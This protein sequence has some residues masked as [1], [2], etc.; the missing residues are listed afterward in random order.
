MNLNNS[1]LLTNHLKTYLILIISLITNRI[2]NTKFQSNLTQQNNNNKT[3]INN[4]NKNN[5]KNNNKNNSIPN[6]NTHNH[7]FKIQVHVNQ[8]NLRN[9]RSQSILQLCLQLEKKIKILYLMLN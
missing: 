1:I 2:V 8:Q 7:N 4:N 5:K 9:K 6:N 3:K